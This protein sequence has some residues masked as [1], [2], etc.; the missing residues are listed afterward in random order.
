MRLRV[1]RENLP[2]LAT[3]G[4]CAALYAAGCA[5]FERFGSWG[6]VLGFFDQYAY[7]GIVSVGMTFVILSG[8][9]NLSV[10]SMM[11]LS[12]VLIG[13][14]VMKLGVNPWLAIA[15]VLAAGTLLG[16]AMGGLIAV[17]DLPPFLITLG[18]MFFCRGVALLISR[19]AFAIDHPVY[20]SLAEFFVPIAGGE[21][22]YLPAVAFLAVLLAGIFVARYTA[23]GR[24]AYAIG[25]SEA[26]AVLMG[27]PVVR[28]KVLIYALGGLCSALGGVVYTVYTPSADALTGTGLE[29]EAIAAV[30]VGGTLLTG[31]AGGVAGTLFGVLIFAIIR[32]MLAFQGTLG[33]GAARIAVGFLLMIFVFL[34]KVIQ[35]KR[36]RS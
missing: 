5:G 32:Q 35:G 19:R 18:G 34:Q 36:S 2:F 28:T 7:L 4:V 10:G 31:G 15:A 20:D 25:G 17:F 27:L 11:A 24:N 22:L 30:V 6:V 21:G 16:L 8:G 9:I 29:L 3:V 1:G 26:S 33:P 23:F 12:T 14:L 13:T